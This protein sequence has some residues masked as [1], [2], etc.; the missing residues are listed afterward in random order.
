MNEPQR[1][2]LTVN[3]RI[4][5]RVFD[6][7][8]RT[9]DLEIGGRF[10]GQISEASVWLMTSFRRVPSLTMSVP[11]NFFPTVATNFGP[12][13]N[14]VQW[15]KTSNSLGRGILTYP[16]DWSDSQG[17]ISEPTT[18][19]CNRLIPY[20][21]MLCGLIVAMPECVDDVKDNLMLAWFPAGEELG[22]HSFYEADEVNWVDEDLD[23]AMVD[24]IQLTDHHAYQKRNRKGSPFVGRLAPGHRPHWRS[25]GGP[26]P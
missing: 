24:L 5:Q 23:A 4:L 18:D 22:V 11:L 17:R 8:H 20:S 26:Q 3:A 14:S 16:T 6:E 21:G 7:V 10:F 15:M 19:A 1:P 12:W 13:I 9:P 25:L 2:T